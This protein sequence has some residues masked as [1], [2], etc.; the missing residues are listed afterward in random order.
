MR[1]PL[2]QRPP[3]TDRRAVLAGRSMNALRL[4]V[5]ALASVNGLRVPVGMSRRAALG[6][7]VATFAPPL[8]PKAIADDSAEQPSI[9]EST[10]DI[11]LANAIATTFA[12]TFEE[13]KQLI[14]A[15]SAFTALALMPVDQPK[16]PSAAPISRPSDN[17]PND[18]INT[19]VWFE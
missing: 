18:Q 11:P 4:L 2:P 8:V 16:T 6:G 1:W 3:R 13:E 17:E 9:V 5:V 12:T 7:L 10:T 14:V 15:I 19:D